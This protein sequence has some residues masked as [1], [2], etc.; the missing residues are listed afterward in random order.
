MKNKLILT[1]LVAILII[2]GLV[3]VKKTSTPTE[4]DLTSNTNSGTSTIDGSDLKFED[5]ESPFKRAASTSTTETLQEVT[6][7]CDD[8]KMITAIIYV[9]GKD[10]RAQVNLYESVKDE[11]G[12]DLSGE[13]RTFIL[14]ERAA[15]SGPRYATDNDSIVFWGR[16]D[17]AYIEENGKSVFRGC[18]LFSSSR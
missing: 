8:S 2:A 5:M 6:F 14:K 18:E 3:F 17:E 16:G 4:L 7:K 12:N 13:S 1:I 11:K 10:P 15:L 9:G